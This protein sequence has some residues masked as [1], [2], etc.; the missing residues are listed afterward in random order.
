MYKSRGLYIPRSVMQLGA[1]G[2]RTLAVSAPKRSWWFYLY[3]RPGVIVS[4]QLFDELIS[5]WLMKLIFFGLF[6][7]TMEQYIGIF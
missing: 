3:I 4:Q 7:G 6:V 5:R 2:A 1:A